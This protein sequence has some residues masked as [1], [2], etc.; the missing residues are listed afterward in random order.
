MNLGLIGVRSRGDTCDPVP[1]HKVPPYPP[2]CRSAIDF[3]ALCDILIAEGFAFL[4][5]WNR[6]SMNKKVEEDKYGMPTVR[7]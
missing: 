6:N 4:P 3:L 7:R 5:F 1:S 2:P